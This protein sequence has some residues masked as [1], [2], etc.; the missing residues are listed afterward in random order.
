M[1]YLAG[2]YYVEVKDHRYKMH[3]TEIIILRK[4]D[5]PT[6]LRTQN[7]VQNQTQIRRNHKVIKNDNNQLMVKN[8]P[9]NKQP[10][11]Q[12]QKFVLTNCPSCKIWINM[13]YSTYNSTE[14]M[15][16]KLQDLKRKTKLKFYKNISTYYNEMKDKNFQ[17]QED[18]F[19]RNAQGISKIYLEVLLLMKFLQTKPQVKNVNNYFYDLYDTVIK[20]RRENDN[21]EEQKEIVNDDNEYINFNDIITPYYYVGIKPLESILR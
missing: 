11:K 10:I 16:N 6:S 14:V 3:P 15:I 5:P 17:T 12:Q 8:Y 13:V 20:N 2:N 7:Q 19:S 9:K 4:R 21:E 1:K 18:P